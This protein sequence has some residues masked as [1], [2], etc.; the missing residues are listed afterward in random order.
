[1]KSPQTAAL[2]PSR[3]NDFRKCPLQFRLTVVDR[4]PQPPAPA[5][6]RG[7]LV[8]SVL[9]QLYDRQP[10]ERTQQVATD[11]VGP[12]WDAMTTKDPQLEG[13]LFVDGLTREQFLDQARTLVGSYFALENPV[14]LQP[15]H[16][17]EYIRT[18]VGD[19]LH[20][21]GFIDRVDVAPG[22]LVRLVDYKT[23]KA[24]NPAYLGPYLFQLRFYALAWRNLTGQAPKRLQL[25]FLKS[26][27]TY[28]HDPSEDE[29]DAT[30][31]EL[32][33]LWGQIE[34]AAR[35]QD[36]QPRRSK[37]CDWCDVRSL[38][39]LFDG[40]TPPIPSEGIDRLLSTHA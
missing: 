16:R 8:H 1:M 32:M 23:G 36:F 20:I 3:A 4:I 30:E 11:M 15:A 18:D 40:T 34:Q 25:L 26:E 9:E 33:L 22:G 6:E 7:T 14:N 10:H 38:C 17:E 37:L 12:T 31:D 21:H 29:L 24:P 27:M 5:R 2:S 13:Q 39:P 35:A 28:T 19:G